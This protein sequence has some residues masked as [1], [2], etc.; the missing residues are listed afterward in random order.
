[1]QKVFVGIG[2]GAIQLGLW[3][4]YA[5]RKG[6][7]VVLSEVDEGRVKDIR[8][9]GNCYHIN[10]ARFDRVVS[11][12][13]GPVDICNPSVR[14]DRNRLLAA[15]REANDI[16]TAVPS[17]KVYEKGGI[18]ALLAEG[19]SK[20]ERPVLIYAS[21][22]QI[23]A[24]RQLESLAFP[25][26]RPAR[27]ELSET[28]IE[29]MGGPQDDPELIGKL[30]LETITPGKGPA[31][32]VEEF[33]QIRVEH[34][35]LSKRE[36]Y[37]SLFTMF[38]PT[39]HIHF[40]EELKLLGHNAVHFLLGTL[41]KHKGYT[42]MSEWNGDPDFGW[43]GV[44]ALMEE[45]GGWF[46]KNYVSAGEAVATEEGYSRWTSE[47][48]RRIV[49]PF[50]YDRVDRIIRDADRKLGWEDRIIGTMRKA[51]EAGVEPRR[52]ALGVAA[53]LMLRGQSS[54]CASRVDKNA[55]LARLE[56]AWGKEGDA[57]MRGR[58][59]RTVEPALA[60]VQEWKATGR[61]DLY[62]F[63]LEKGYLS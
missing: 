26:G 1:M 4:Y 60:L 2:S 18:A 16:V 6:A 14:E 25:G 12:K 59:L 55:A 48:A 11:V 24:A 58:I 52:F 57:A 23:G 8:S 41:G 40:F 38:F 20:P 45:T 47:L 39:S 10:L 63:L 28:V 27:V 31:L 19:L 42:F 54:A 17:T 29:R 13:I 3:A 46:K 50:L 15:I 51:L 62:H 61:R 34:E 5:F 32:L 22:N 7:K 43:I 44:D 53:A 21:E 9:N 56:A 30:H 49:N 33:D 37:E 36:P 35:T